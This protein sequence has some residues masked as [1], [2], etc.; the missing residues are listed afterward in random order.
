[1][2]QIQFE[3]IRSINFFDELTYIKI[4]KTNR[5]NKFKI[6]SKFL[7]FRMKYARITKIVKLI[8]MCE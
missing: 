4:G 3:Y 5:P 7:Q 1:M 2:N 6:L 8:P